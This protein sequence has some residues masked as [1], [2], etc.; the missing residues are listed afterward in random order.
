VHALHVFGSLALAFA[1]C[2]LIGLER[3]LRQKSAGLRTH[4]LVGLAAA[5]IMVTSKYG[6]ADVLS[7]TRIVLDPSRIAAQVVSGIGFIGGGVIFVRRDVVR[8]LTTAAVVWL[9][10]AVG[11]ACGAGLYLVATAV[12]AGHFVV[13]YVYT[14]LVRRLPTSRRGPWTFRLAYRDQQGV[15]RRALAEATKRGFAVT[16]LELGREADRAGIVGVDLEV[17]GPGQVDELTTALGELDGVVGVTVRT[18]DE[19]AT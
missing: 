6:F 4:T 13:V 5:T 16:E 17:Q 2:S 19:S 8:G 3:E 10:A 1:L 11:L 12:T 18:V 7:P 14:P 15:L 9:A